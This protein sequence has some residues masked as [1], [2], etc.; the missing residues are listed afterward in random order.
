MKVK[1]GGEAAI[2]AVGAIAG[3][4]ANGYV[5][6]STMWEVVEAVLGIAAVAVGFYHD[7]YAGDFVEGLG[8]G[9]LVAEG[10]SFM[11]K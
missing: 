6:K 3:M 2:A 9:L 7:G 1:S 5:P 11:R 10:L 8:V 4:Y